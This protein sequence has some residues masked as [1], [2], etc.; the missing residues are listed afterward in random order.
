[1]NQRM[2]INFKYVLY[3]HI[4]WHYYAL[5]GFF[6]PNMLLEVN[7]ALRTCLFF[8]ANQNI[9]AAVRAPLI[10][11]AVPREL[12]DATAPAQDAPVETT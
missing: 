6:P 4:H 9:A 1:M 7:N 2:Q 5:G 11:S 8:E 3:L 12:Y 10:S